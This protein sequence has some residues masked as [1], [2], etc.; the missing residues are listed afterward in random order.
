AP[1][2]TE[3]SRKPILVWPNEIP[4]EGTPERNVAVMQEVAA[5]LSTSEQPK[6]YLYASPGL[7]IP[8]FAAEFIP[9]VMNNVQTRFVGAGIHYIQE[10]Q[11]EVIGRNISDWIRDVV[12]AGG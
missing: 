1:Y 12:N 4:I 5:W 10:D 7:I 6:L 9:Q 8:P 3:D 11:P 2:P